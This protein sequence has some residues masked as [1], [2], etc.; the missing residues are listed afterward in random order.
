MTMFPSRNQKSERT[1]C[2]GRSSLE[3]L[4]TSPIEAKEFTQRRS[5]RTWVGDQW[6]VVRRLRLSSPSPIWNWSGAQE[7]GDSCKMWNCECDQ[8]VK[9]WCYWSTQGAISR[10]PNWA[11]RVARSST[12]MAFFLTLERLSVSRRSWNFFAA[13]CLKHPTRRG[14]VVSVSSHLNG[15]W[16][17]W[18]LGRCCDNCKPPSKPLS[19]LPT[20][21]PGSACCLQPSLS[22][23]CFQSYPVL[24]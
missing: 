24:I 15:P 19:R 6:V 2:L 9:Y 12:T 1:K 16:H 10:V 22:I 5:R 7:A 14:C 13:T 18:R 8:R 11:F 4:E 3:I 20:I 23:N 21:R 17:V